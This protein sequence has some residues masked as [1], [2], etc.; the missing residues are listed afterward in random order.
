MTRRR[1]PPLDRNAPAGE[2]QLAQPRAQERLGGHVVLDRASVSRPQPGLGSK[3]FRC[4]AASRSS[5]R[6]VM[7]EHIEVTQPAGG[8]RG[9]VEPSRDQA[10]V[11]GGCRRRAPGRLVDPDG[12]GTARWRPAESGRSWARTTTLSRQARHVGA[13]VRPWLGPPP[14]GPGTASTRYSPA[15]DAAQVGRHHPNADS[16]PRS[17][18]PR[19]GRVQ[20]AGARRLLDHPATM[21]RPAATLRSGDAHRLS[22]RGRW[23]AATT[24]SN[25]AMASRRRC[26]GPTAGA[27]RPLA[28]ARAFTGT[29]GTGIAGNGTMRRAW[30]AAGI[31]STPWPRSSSRR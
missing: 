6:S 24:S 12:P 4:P 7:V 19:Q 5:G 22:S 27:R 11:L 20:V 13:V 9:R 10:E 15:A 14:P 31:P 21:G 23:R 3:L 2:G 18:R 29:S 1:P 16:S 25:M 26:S 28:S 30:P 8:D 17:G